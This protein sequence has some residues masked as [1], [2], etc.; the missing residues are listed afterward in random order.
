MEIYLYPLLLGVSAHLFVGIIAWLSGLLSKFRYVFILAVVLGTFTVMQ[1]SV[2]KFQDRV[3]NGR[4]WLGNDIL[5]TP[6]PIP[7]E[8][9]TLPGI[10]PITDD[11]VIHRTVTHED[12]SVE[13]VTPGPAYPVG[14]AQEGL[15]GGGGGSW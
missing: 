4:D 7:E 15:G 10:A 11:V 9:G 14:G 6:I 1:V 3:E 2:E 5:P 12:G 8:V 13:D